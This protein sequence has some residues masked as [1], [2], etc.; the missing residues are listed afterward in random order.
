LVETELSRVTGISLDVLAL[1]RGP[2]ALA[3]V[4]LVIL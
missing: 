3:I 4:P 1:S 2:L